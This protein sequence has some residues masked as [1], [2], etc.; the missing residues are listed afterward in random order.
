[1]IPVPSYQVLE[2]LEWLSKFQFRL[3]ENNIRD[4]RLLE[5]A[6]EYLRKGIGI[7]GQHVD[8]KFILN[9]FQ[10]CPMVREPTL[11]EQLDHFCGCGLC[12]EYIRREGRGS[13]TTSLHPLLREFLSYSERTG[14]RE[15]IEDR[16]HSEYGREFDEI[17]SHRE[18]H[19]WFRKLIKIIGSNLNQ[20]FKEFLAEVPKTLIRDFESNRRSLQRRGEIG[21]NNRRE[22]FHDQNEEGTQPITQLDNP[23]EA[24]HRLVM[25]VQELI[26]G[27]HYDHIIATDHHLCRFLSVASDFPED[28]AQSLE[29]LAWLWEHH[30][31]INITGDIPSENLSDLIQLFCE[32]KGYSNVTSFSKTVKKWIK[33]E[34][35]PSILRRISSFIWRNSPSRIHRESSNSTFERY[36]TVRMHAMF[37]FLSLGDFPSFIEKHW[38]DLN[39][40][41]GDYLDVYYSKQDLKSRVSGFET[42]TKFKSLK[43]GVDQLPAIILWRRSLEE[44]YSISLGNLPHDEIMDVMKL[45]VHRI[46]EGDELDEIRKEATKHIGT[47]IKDYSGPQVK[48]NFFL[49]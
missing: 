34:S 42:L 23:E 35:S 44:A 29:F 39:A 46:S 17:R 6:T 32:A 36:K 25:S 43:I 48:D 38:V 24:A 31:R 33:G 49:N 41:T 20:V 11:G 30:P 28:L 2:F 9:V 21:D 3:T 8:L 10:S 12:L 45:I 15:W 16:L 13:I 22:R 18:D 4:E 27:G 47:R 1:M 37:L 7:H 19:E 14:F 26:R 5:L 40:L